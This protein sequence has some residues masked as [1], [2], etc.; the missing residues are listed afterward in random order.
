M[1]MILYRGITSLTYVWRYTVTM[2][3]PNG[4][5]KDLGLRNRC[6]SL[7]HKNI[8]LGFIIDKL[9]TDLSLEVMLFQDL[10]QPY[11]QVVYS[12]PARVLVS[13]QKIN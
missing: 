1:P 3:E 6:Y 5:N 10:P 8:G 11:R 2:Q 7:E 13:L 4:R 9:N 12:L